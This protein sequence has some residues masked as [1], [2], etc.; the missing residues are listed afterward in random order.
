[1]SLTS[2]NR[3]LRA[4][5]AELLPLALNRADELRDI[6]RDSLNRDDVTAAD[7]ASAAIAA[8]MTASASR[9]PANVPAPSTWTLATDGGRPQTDGRVNLNFSKDL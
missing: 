1:M 5:I 9:E 6:A 3:A 7:A 2:D 4:T 8:A